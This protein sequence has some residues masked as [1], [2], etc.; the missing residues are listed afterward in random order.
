[1]TEIARIQRD[2]LGK[3]YIPFQS[4]IGKHIFPK[5][6]MTSKDIKRFRE[7][8]VVNQAGV[9][10]EEPHHG[11]DVSTTKKDIKDLIRTSFLGQWIFFKDQK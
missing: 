8:I 9:D 10:T 11:Y 7:D 3:A 6:P 5:S 2:G 1:M 4:P